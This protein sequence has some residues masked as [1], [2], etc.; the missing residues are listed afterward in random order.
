MADSSVRT[1]S[2]SPRATVGI[3][4]S[5]G[6]NI[7]A[8]VAFEDAGLFDELVLMHPLIPWTPD[9]NPHWRGRAC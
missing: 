6:A 4:D 1:R 7:L 2:A 8:A 9:D 5:N 3:G